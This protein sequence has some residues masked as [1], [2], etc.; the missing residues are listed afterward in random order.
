EQVAIEGYPI[1]E[2]RGTPTGA[3]A[4]P[5]LLSDPRFRFWLGQ[6]DGGPVSLGT[7]PVA[8]VAGPGT[9]HAEGHAADAVRHRRT[10]DRPR[11][12]GRQGCG[13]RPTGCTS[14]SPTRLRSPPPTP[15]A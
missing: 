14:R 6:E 11:R 2:L 4:D 5:R 3:L 15:P 1:D 13:G 10:V 7:L 12:A 8:A 9:G